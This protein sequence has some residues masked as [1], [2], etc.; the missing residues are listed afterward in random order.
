MVSRFALGCTSNCSNDGLQPNTASHE[1]QAKS[2][3]SSNLFQPVPAHFSTSQP[4]VDPNLTNQ[5]GDA[6]LPSSFTP[7]QQPRFQMYVQPQSTPRVPYQF[8]S[9]TADQQLFQTTQPPQQLNI[10]CFPSPSQGQFIV[11]LLQYCPAQNS[12]CFGCGNTLKPNASIPAPPGDLVIVSKMARDRM[13]LPRPPL[14]KAFKCV[15]SLR[16]FMHTMKATT[17]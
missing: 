14:Q 6:I 11:Y 8:P 7:T 3:Q 5:S 2:H 10:P 12:V 16:N 9:A 13:V 4:F 17:F 1:G 15:F